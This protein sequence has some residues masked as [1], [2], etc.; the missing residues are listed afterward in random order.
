M[1]VHYIPIRESSSY[2]SDHR[3]ICFPCCTLE[4]HRIHATHFIFPQQRVCFSS[5]SVTS[6]QLA[7]LLSILVNPSPVSLFAFVPPSTSLL[8]FLHSA[9]SF[10]R[11][12][13]VI[14]RWRPNIYSRTQKTYIE[15]DK[16]R[17]RERGGIERRKAPAGRLLQQSTVNT[18]QIP[19]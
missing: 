13:P 15:R 17:E 10:H 14:A 7:P 18:P 4:H 1:L 6:L 11:R 3:Q 12:S 2:L 9:H 19:Q 5:I 16:E 8:R